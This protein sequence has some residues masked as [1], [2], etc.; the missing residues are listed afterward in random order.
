MNFPPLPLQCYYWIGLAI[1][2]FLAHGHQGGFLNGVSFPPQKISCSNGDVMGWLT[3]LA[4]P[5]HSQPQPWSLS[6]GQNHT[7]GIRRRACCRIVERSSSGGEAFQM[8]WNGKIL[9]AK[10][11][12]L[13]VLCR[14]EPAARGTFTQCSWNKAPAWDSRSSLP[15]SSP[16]QPPRGW[17]SLVTTKHSPGREF[18]V[19]VM[20]DS[21]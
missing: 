14:Q 17:G 3:G 20:N 11:N 21:S 15:S 16:T 13:E 19:P 1:P 2:F 5:E 10:E 7:A 12:F 9:I 6:P 18:A 8:I 4:R